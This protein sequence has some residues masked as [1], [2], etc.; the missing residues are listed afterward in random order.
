[1]HF[2]AWRQRAAKHLHPRLRPLFELIPPT[3]LGV[4]FLSLADEVNP[5]D[6]LEQLRSTTGPW[7]NTVPTRSGTR[8]SGDSTHPAP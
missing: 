6:P 8:W 7:T 4:D 1:M 5:A 2:G 3:G